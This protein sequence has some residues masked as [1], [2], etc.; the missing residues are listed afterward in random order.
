MAGLYW[1]NIVIINTI[2]LI[3]HDHCISCVCDLSISQK[4][5]PP[6]SRGRHMIYMALMHDVFNSENLAVED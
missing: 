3:R 6:L 4:F 1:Y 2:R 5:R